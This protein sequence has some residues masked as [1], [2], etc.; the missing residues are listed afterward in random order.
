ME[1]TVNPQDIVAMVRNLAQPLAEARGLELFEVEYKPGGRMLRVFLDRRNGYVDI[2]DCSVV[3]QQLSAEL[4]RLDF[5]PHAYRLEVSSPGLDRPLRNGDDYRRFSGQRARFVLT[6]PL[7]GMASFS[8]Q[9]RE[10]RQEVVNIV[11]AGGESLWVPLGQV[12]SARL[13][14]ETAPDRD[15]AGA[16]R[17]KRTKQP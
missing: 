10:C 7:N 16:G 2:G 15:P 4:D 11:L 13:E 6:Q 8:G 5:I 12:K 14:I 3:S 1:A 9:I 17:K